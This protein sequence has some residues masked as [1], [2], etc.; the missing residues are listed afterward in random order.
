[1]EPSTKRAVISDSFL[2]A[3]TRPIQA[4][5]WVR[6]LN[7]VVGDIRNNSTSTGWF[8]VRL[9]GVLAE[10]IPNYKRLRDLFQTISPDSPQYLPALQKVCRAL[11]SVR[12]KYTKE[13]LL[14]IEYMRHCQAHVFQN[15]YYRTVANG[16]PKF[17]K[18]GGILGDEQLPRIELRKAI[19]E[20][21]LSYR[22]DE[23]A[24]A[25]ALAGRIEEEIQGV[26]VAL[27]SFN[28]LRSS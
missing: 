1:M 20:I 25:V 13:E 2:Q 12:A 22:A 8:W 6:N 3:S 24:A 15:S 10:L 28:S 16:K 21:L 9:Y 14:F 5:Q 27:E 11:D 17:N 23:D 18:G 26:V 7:F 19:N 4:L